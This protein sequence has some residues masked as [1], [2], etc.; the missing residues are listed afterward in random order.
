[1]ES[2]RYIANRIDTKSEGRDRAA[3]DSN[4]EVEAICYKLISDY[5]SCEKKKR[6]QLINIVVKNVR[7]IGLLG[8]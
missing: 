1:M 2:S 5:L 3:W 6:Y 4:G 7:L 8:F